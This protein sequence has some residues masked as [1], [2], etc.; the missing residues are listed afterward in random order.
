MPPPPPVAATRTWPA[1]FAP[2]PG[3]R[4]PSRDDRQWGAEWFARKSPLRE[5]RVRSEQIQRRKVPWLAAATSYFEIVTGAEPF[6]ADPSIAKGR[7]L[8]VGVKGGAG[9]GV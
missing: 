9:S 3:D 4:P 8:G 2:A 7:F 5:L 1:G 6:G